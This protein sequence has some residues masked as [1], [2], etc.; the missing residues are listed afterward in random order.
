MSLEKNLYDINA[1]RPSARKLL[2]LI[3]DA[4]GSEEHV[5]DELATELKK[6]FDTSYDDFWRTEIGEHV[7][8]SRLDMRDHILGV[9]EGFRS[10][11][12]YMVDDLRDALNEAANRAIKEMA[13]RM[14]TEIE[15]DETKE[16]GPSR[17][18]SEGGGGSDA[19]S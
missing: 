7:T 14:G 12:D 15:E 3:Q 2:K 6:M 11:I 19:A 9:A 1:W 18:T 16:R 10:E 8:Q 4:E 5:I 17:E 13:T